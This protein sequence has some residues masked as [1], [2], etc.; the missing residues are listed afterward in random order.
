MGERIG[1]RLGHRAEACGGAVLC[2]VGLSILVE[3]LC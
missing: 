2:I 1:T 3:H